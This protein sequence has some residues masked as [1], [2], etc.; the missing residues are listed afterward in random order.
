VSE[1][2]YNDQQLRLHAMQMAVKHADSVE[3][4]FD[5]DLTRIAQEI[6]DFIK[7]ETK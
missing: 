3:H 2:Q 5:V 6:Y 1:E 7:G 4:A